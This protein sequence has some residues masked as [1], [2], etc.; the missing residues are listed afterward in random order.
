MPVSSI[1]RGL[2]AAM[3]LACLLAVFPASPAR[4][5]AY[6]NPFASDTV[7]VG[8]TDMGV[9]ICLAAGQP[10]DALGDGVIAGILPNWYAGQPYLYYELTDGPD[11]GRYVYVAEQVTPRVAVGT[12]VHAGDVIGRYARHGSCLETGWSLADGETQAQASPA[13]YTEGSATAPGVSFARLLLSLGVPGPFELTVTQV[14]PTVARR[15]TPP[16]VPPSQPIAPVSHPAAPVA[17][18]AA[19]VSHPAAPAA[20]AVVHRA[21]RRHRSARPTSRHPGRPV[22]SRPVA[23]PVQVPTVPTTRA[24]PPASS[25]SSGGAT[26]TGPPD[27]GAS[28]A[29][30]WWEMPGDPFAA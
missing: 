23:K 4:A 21:A 7:T 6:V 22:A 2:S 30:P 26:V 28:P 24:A 12:I 14:H 13:G 17:R 5:A 1:R 18:P 27:Q 15:P 16:A 29:S 20:T 10:I 11:A 25:V 3:A 8:R 9:D 19:P